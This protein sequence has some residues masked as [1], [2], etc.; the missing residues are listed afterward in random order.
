MSAAEALA[1][2]LPPLGLSGTIERIVEELGAVSTALRELPEE[3]HALTE[4]VAKLEPG[5]AAVEAGLHIAANTIPVER[6][7]E[8]LGGSAVPRERLVLAAASLARCVRPGGR[9]DPFERMVLALFT[10]GE[11]PDRRL[12]SR[13]DADPLLAQIC[14]GAA[15]DALAVVE[16][17]TFLVKVRE[18][19]ESAASIGELLSTGLYLELRGFRVALGDALLDRDVLWESAA[20]NLAIANLVALER[21][22]LGTSPHARLAKVDREVDAMF[23]ASHPAAAPSIPLPPPTAAE[24]PEDEDAALAAPPAESFRP[25]RWRRAAR[26]A[27]IAVVLALT[28][29]AWLTQPSL[30][31]LRAIDPAELAAVDPLLRA[32]EWTA[33]E[34]RTFVG[35]LTDEWHGLD[36]KARRVAAERIAAGLEARGVKA[37]MLFHAG[38]PAARIRDGKVVAS[39]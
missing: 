7:H 13:E 29:A 19:F 28:A 34:P 20:V 25:S 39:L 17:R 31:R 33:R 18:R 5:L 21:S 3:P 26:A 1:A 16:A 30:D 35:T 12:R 6:L 15:P 36:A 23:R 4:A 2:A 22:V 32:G 37:A 27:G 24:P 14:G 9:N 10:E 11:E 38:R 8:R